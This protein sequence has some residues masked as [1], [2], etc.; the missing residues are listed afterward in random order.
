MNKD[1]GFKIQPTAIMCTIF[2]HKAAK[3]A[4]QKNVS[5]SFFILKTVQA[6]KT[7]KAILSFHVLL[8]AMQHISH[9]EMVLRE[10]ISLLQQNRKQKPLILYFQQNT[11][12]LF[13]SKV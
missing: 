10:N 3:V 2:T 4:E 13:T 12:Y 9:K 7:Y 5:L 6:L 8:N 1:A 11:I